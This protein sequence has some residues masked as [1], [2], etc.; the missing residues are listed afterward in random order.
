MKAQE[1]ASDLVQ[2][3]NH[4]HLRSFK[5]SASLLGAAL[6]LLNL[7]DIYDTAS[8][9]KRE[10]A[11]MR[12][13]TPSLVLLLAAPSIASSFVATHSLRLQQAPGEFKQR[14]FGSLAKS[15]H[16]VFVVPPG[17]SS[18]QQSAPTP[19]EDGSSSGVPPPPSAISDGATIPP[20]PVTAAATTDTATSS[21][22]SMMGPNSS[23]PGVLRKTFSN[24]P[25]HR[26]PNMLTYMRCLAIPASV[27]IFYLPNGGNGSNVASGVIFG[28][29]SATDWLDGYLA[30][31]WDIASS[32]GAFLDPVAD[33]L[34]VS[35]SLILLA[36]RFGKGT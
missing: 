17:G 24:L 13:L 31:R 11:M 35:T 8:T 28:L 30:R 9:L 36:G 3:G 32:F 7:D 19:P 6:L 2:V 29:A 1:R 12:L 20:P 27:A 34:M 14:P 33:K 23:Q 16:R 10:S 15:S 21:Y 22:S 4:K 26:L 18:E 25:W 5:V